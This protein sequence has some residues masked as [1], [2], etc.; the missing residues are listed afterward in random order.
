MILSALTGMSIRR[1]GRGRVLFGLEGASSFIIS[2][3]VSLMNMS[4]VS[5]F[6]QDFGNLDVSVLMPA[7]GIH[8][9]HESVVMMSRRLM[10]PTILDIVVEQVLLLA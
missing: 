9:A 4:F 5:C 10:S 2:V 1:R 8:S 3:R 6:P 7:G